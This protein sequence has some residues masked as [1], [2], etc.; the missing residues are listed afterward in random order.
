MFIQQMP[1]QLVFTVSV[2]LITSLLMMVS[3]GLFAPEVIT[4]LVEQTSP[5]RVIK[6]PMDQLN[7][8][9]PKQNV[10]V[11]NQENFA[12]KTVSTKHLETAQQASFVDVMPQSVNQL[13]VSLVTFA[14][15][16]ITA[17]AVQP[18]QSLVHREH[19]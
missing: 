8:L 16:D 13:T 4:V 2:G 11:V 3:Q 19:L 18:F 1:V 6:V 10:R 17:P 15:L 5:S 12:Q 9:A 14:G 7:S